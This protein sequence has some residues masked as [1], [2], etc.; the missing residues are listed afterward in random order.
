[1]C[2]FGFNGGCVRQT[3]QAPVQSGICVLLSTNCRS[4]AGGPCRLQDAA[5]QSHLNGPAARAH[6]E[7]VKQVLKV[8]LHRAC[9][10]H[11]LIGDMLVRI[12]KPEQL[13][14]GVFAP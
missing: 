10:Q 8:I 3:A 5:L 11:E 7:F 12:F 14:H 9:G 6:A 2:G 4:T 1:M 13:E